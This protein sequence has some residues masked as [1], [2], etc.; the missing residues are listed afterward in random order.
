M[1]TGEY[2]TALVMMKTVGQLHGH[3]GPCR[4][5]RLEELVQELDAV[6]ATLGDTNFTANVCTF[7]GLI[8]D[9]WGLQK[10]TYKD[11]ASYLRS[12]FLWTMARLFSEHLDFWKVGERLTIDKPLA[13]KIS[14][15][16]VGDRHIIDLAC[17]TGPAGPMLYSLLRDHINKGRRVR[18]LEQ[19]SL[20]GVRPTVT[21]DDG[22]EESSE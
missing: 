14:T 22:S 5:H 3:V 10:I 1:K 21:D 7:F 16:P 4:T 12:N 2:M 8:D 6:A 15:F 17:S 19:R 20:D 11:G 18:Q 9:C 13:A